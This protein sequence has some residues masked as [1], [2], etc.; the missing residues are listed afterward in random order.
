MAYFGNIIL[1]CST[2]LVSSGLF[3]ITLHKGIFGFRILFAFRISDIIIGKVN[4]N[5]QVS[6]WVFVGLGKEWKLLAV[7]I[8][9]R[10]KEIIIQKAAVFFSTSYVNSF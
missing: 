2:K 4:K 10:T 8:I 5:P 7:A 6:W 9:N 1:L 3:R